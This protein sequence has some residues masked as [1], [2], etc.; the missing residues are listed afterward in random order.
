M[1]SNIYTNVILTLIAI[2][3]LMIVIKLADLPGTA[4]ADV[5]P[6]N[7]SIWVDGGHLYVTIDNADELARENYRKLDGMSVDAD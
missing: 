5:P 1:K 4:V 7:Q 6:P 2:F 3:L